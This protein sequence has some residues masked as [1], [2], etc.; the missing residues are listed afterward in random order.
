ME[1]T[2]WLSAA[3]FSHEGTSDITE[4]DATSREGL[5]RPRAWC[6]CLLGTE[7]SSILSCFPFP[8]FFSFFYSLFL[9]IYLSF[10]HFFGHIL[11][12]HS[13]GRVILIVQCL[14]PSPIHP[15]LC[16]IMCGL[17]CDDLTQ[18]LFSGNNRKSYPSKINFTSRAND[19]MYQYY[20]PKQDAICERCYGPGILMRSRRPLQKPTVFNY[21]SSC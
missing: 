9:S 1:I 5:K 8:S 7:S 14:A 2:I 13:N 21:D 17:T 11:F 12:C 4:W 20:T 18:C 15:W 19:H 16:Q 6:G 3:A 10:F